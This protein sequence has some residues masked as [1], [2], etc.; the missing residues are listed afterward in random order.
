MKIMRILAV[1]AL[2]M[3]AGTLATTQQ[4]AAQAP[5]PAVVV[6]PVAPWPVWVLGGGVI[7]LMVRAAVVQNQQ[8]RELTTDEAITGMVPLWPLYQREDNRCRRVRPGCEAY[9]PP[10]QVPG[11]VTAEMVVKPPRR[12]IP[13]RCRDA[14]VPVVAG[15]VIST[16]Y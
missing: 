7:S 10:Q 8:C 3:T 9:A 12:H 6:T 1:A 13:N 4:A 14:F 5:A 2:G 16:R 11:A 15:P